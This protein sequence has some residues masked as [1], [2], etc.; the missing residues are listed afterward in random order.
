[1]PGKRYDGQFKL[2][3]ARLV[4]K[5]LIPVKRLTD[6]LDVPWRTF[7]RSAAEYENDS[8]DASPGSCKP[9][10]N[11]DYEIPKFKKGNGELRKEITILNPGL[12]WASPS[13]R[14]ELVRIG[15]HGMSVKK[16]CEAL[17]SFVEDIPYAN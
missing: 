2:S 9:T 12:L 15:E 1:M 6:Q 4:L 10:I 16:A 14:F 17:E 13:V 3:A 7:R 5:E 11:K 8:E